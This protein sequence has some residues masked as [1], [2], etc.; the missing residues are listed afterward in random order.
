MWSTFFSH[1]PQ[2][3]TRTIVL[4]LP[5]L[6]LD[7]IMPALEAKL[8]ADQRRLQE[9]QWQLLVQ[10]CL[11]C[12]CPLY[13]E[14]AYSESLLWTSFSPQVNL[15]LPAS[16]KGLYLGLLARLERNLGRQLVRRAASLISISRWGVTQE[17][18]K[19]TFNYN[20]HLIFFQSLQYYSASVLDYTQQSNMCLIISPINMQCAT[21]LNSWSNLVFYVPLGHIISLIFV[22]LMTHSSISPL[23]II[24]LLS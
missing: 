15:S 2:Q 9:Q 23:I 24:T 17:V 22:M 20:L 18:G 4:S 10:A 3:S 11:S 13:L 16:L 7:D 14:A 5:P 8:R 12:P 19:T 6:S 1:P 21:R